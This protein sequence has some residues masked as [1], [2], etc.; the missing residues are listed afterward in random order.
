MSDTKNIFLFGYSGHAYVIIESLLDLGF[1]VKGYFDFN[2]AKS[3]PYHLEYLGF[4]KN[5][6]LKDIVK[7]NFVFPS[8]GDNKIREKL[9][10]YFD[11]LSLKQI[12]IIDPS[13]K[14]SKSASLGNSTFIAPKACINAQTKIG[15]GVII[16][17][18]AVIDHE[19]FINNYAH[20]APN[21]VL[22]GNV[23][24]GSNSFIGAN[25]VVKN[26]LKITNDILIGAGSVV[27]KSIEEKGI[28]FGNPSKKY[29]SK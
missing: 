13:A 11:E 8:I 18:N 7:D 5:V 28:W 9:I 4:E 19:C 3:N 17:T 6:N 21:A 22:C 26:N 23:I 20:I 29:E 25:T 1:K 24:I 15:K 10:N 16:N 12:S 14:V 27:V 2:E